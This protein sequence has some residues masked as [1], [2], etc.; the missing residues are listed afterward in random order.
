MTLK[1]IDCSL[2][3]IF[4]DVPSKDIA[5]ALFKTNLIALP[6]LHK[7]LLFINGNLISLHRSQSQIK[8]LLSFVHLRKA[9]YNSYGTKNGIQSWSPEEMQKYIFLRQ[10]KTSNNSCP[11]FFP[12]KSEKGTGDASVT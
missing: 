10:I 5:T 7:D 2:I 1:T 12:H 4:L 8:G 11:A 9:I 6:S 3:T